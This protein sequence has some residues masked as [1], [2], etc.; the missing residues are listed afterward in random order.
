[1]SLESNKNQLSNVLSV[2]LSFSYCKNIICYLPKKRSNYFENCEMTNTNDFETFITVVKEYN[3]KPDHTDEEFQAAF[4]KIHNLDYL[5]FDINQIKEIQ[6]A[7]WIPNNFAVKIMKE[8]MHRQDQLLLQIRA[9]LL[10]HP[11]L[12]PE[13]VA[14][15]AKT[16]QNPSLTIDL[17]VENIIYNI[18]TSGGSREFVNPYDQRLITVVQ[19][20][21]LGQKKY[22]V[23]NLFDNKADTFFLSPASNNFFIIISLPPFLKA[24]ITSYTM[25]APPPR[26]N[27][28]NSTG[29]PSNWVLQGLSKPDDETSAFLIDQQINNQDL[30]KPSSKK[31]FDVQQSNPPRYFRHF[32]LMNTGNNHQSN[33]SLALSLFDITGLVIISNE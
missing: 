26:D 13:M 33:L 19:S 5:S 1:M 9:Y 8:W 21:E 17:T 16:I 2:H 6:N 20:S 15:I 18:A 3:S 22:P 10:F 31:T 11:E 32:K 24:S 28:Q 23:S 25:T 29:G 27:F 4:K 30:A 7:K 14:E 12:S